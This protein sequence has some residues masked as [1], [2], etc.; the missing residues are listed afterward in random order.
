MSLVRSRSVFQILALLSLYLLVLPK[1]AI[2]DQAPPT[3]VVQ[4][5]TG[6]LQPFLRAIPADNLAHYG[7]SNEAEFAQARLGEPLRVYT[8]VPD[9]ISNYIPGTDL[10]SLLT[11]T[12]LWYFPVLCFGEARTIL[13]VDLVKGEWRAVAIGSSG[14]AKEVQKLRLRWPSSDGYEHTFVRVFQAQSDFLV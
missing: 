3:E 7:F 1:A 12:N 2:S 4:A 13:T 9:N 5:A 10:T 8:I 6:G 14:L 11:A